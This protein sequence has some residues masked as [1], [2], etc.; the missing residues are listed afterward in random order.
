MKTHFST[1]FCHCGSISV[2][3]NGEKW[4]NFRAVLNKRMLHPRDSA[5]YCDTLNDVVTDFIKRMCYLRQGSPTGDLVP[6]IANEFYRFSLEGTWTTWLCTKLHRHCISL[7]LNLSL[8]H[9]A[10]ASILLETRLGCLEKEIPKGTQEFIN[11]ISKMFSYNFIVTLMPKW[12]RSLLPYWGHYIAGWDGIF[13]F[14]EWLTFILPLKLRRN[15]NIWIFTSI[16]A[17]LLATNL[18]DKK[19]EVLQQRLDDNQDVEGQYLA[20][21]L[22]NTQMSM[23]DVYGNISELLLAGV[24]TVK[25]SLAFTLISVCIS[26]SLLT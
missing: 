15:K 1:F 25:K 3:R 16:S 2:P 24:D 5:Q 19:M 4:Y 6:D 7:N 12:S 23:K 11:S 8:R 22:S 9:S 10:I 13:N 18:I 17:L 21:L 14:G 20:Y 26:L